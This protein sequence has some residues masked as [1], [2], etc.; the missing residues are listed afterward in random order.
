MPAGFY[1]RNGYGQI[2]EAIADA[3]GT[4]GANIKFGSRVSCIE[5][6]D[7]HKVQFEHNGVRETLEADHVWSTIPLTVLIRSVS[8]QPADEIV[9][10][11]EKIAYRAMV[12][13]YLVLEQQQ[14]TQFDAH[15]FP[16]ADV[17]L[18]RLSE[19][20]NYSGVGEPSDRTVL[21][22]ELPCTVN[23]EVWNASNDELT[24]MVRESLERAACPFERPFH[25]PS[26]NACRSRIPYT[27]KD[28][29]DF[30]A[31]RM[32]GSK[33]WT[34]CLL[35]AVRDCSLTTIPTTH[36]PWRTELSTACA[37]R[38]SSIKH[39]GRNTGP[40]SRNMWLRTKTAIEFETEMSEPEVPGARTVLFQEEGTNESLWPKPLRFLIFAAGI[41]AFVWPFFDPH[42]RDGENNFTGLLCLPIA[43]GIG[44][45]VAAL[46][47]GSEWQQTAFWFLLS[48]V[49]LAVSL[50]LVNAGWQLRYQHYKPLEEIFQSNFLTVLLGFCHSGGGCVDAPALIDRANCVVVSAKF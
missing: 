1:P 21:C 10:A 28:T 11:S 39:A 17:R 35:L 23:D 44:V 12:L 5:L 18:T 24:A 34:V 47:L 48:I 32:N 2:T 29:S 50:Q 15:Y 30:S 9:E 49:G 27:V 42:F 19:P 4:F 37:I 14:W 40:S 16:E 20:K 6:G 41:F 36:S 7:S 31:S 38:E 3:A 22:G 45:L 46:A 13:I 25:R 8:P 33:A 43:V 26:Q